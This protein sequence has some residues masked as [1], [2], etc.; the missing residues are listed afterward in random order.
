MQVAQ[1]VLVS[2]AARTLPPAVALNLSDVFLGVFFKSPIVP[3]AFYLLLHG[4]CMRLGGVLIS[5]R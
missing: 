4:C 5:V 3:L 2:I 1:V